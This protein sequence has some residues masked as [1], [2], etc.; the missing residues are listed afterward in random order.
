MD[1][2][3]AARVC[4]GGSLQQHWHL[5]NPMMGVDFANEKRKPC[6]KSAR[7]GNGQGKSHI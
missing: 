2:G 4:A 7:P 5:K 1:S 3:Q 6:R